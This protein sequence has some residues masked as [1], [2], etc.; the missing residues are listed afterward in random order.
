M[1]LEVGYQRRWLVNF[2][3]TDSLTRGV[4]DHTQFGINVPTDARLPNGGGFV[5]DGLYNVTAAAAALGANNFVTSASNFGG[6]TQMAN[7]IN[8]KVTARP[9]RGLSLQG[10]FNGSNTHSDYCDIRSQA[11]RVDGWRRAESGQSLVQH[12]DRVHHALHRLRVVPNPED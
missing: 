11:A 5:L 2:T 12:V 1:S 4:G 8:M 7:S 10:G 9:A 3:V 6:Q